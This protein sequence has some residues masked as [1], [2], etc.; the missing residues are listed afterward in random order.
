MDRVR[1]I[2]GFPEDCVLHEVIFLFEFRDAA[3]RVRIADDEAPQWFLMPRCNPPPNRTI[4]G[5]LER[6]KDLKWENMSSHGVGR[7][8]FRAFID[9]DI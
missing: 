2:V 1:A 3:V 4:N 5:L 8:G 7:H 9:E 6:A